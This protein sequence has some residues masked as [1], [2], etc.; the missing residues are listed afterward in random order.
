MYPGHGTLIADSRTKHGCMILLLILDYTGLL[1]AP[2]VPA[3]FCCDVRCSH[4][5]LLMFH[6]LSFILIRN[7][8]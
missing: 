8:G 2:H 6:S 3:I 7:S 1:H 5:G 4:I